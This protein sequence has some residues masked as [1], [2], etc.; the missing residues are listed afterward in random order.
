MKQPS[1]GVI[2]KD[3]LKISSKFT[4]EHPCQS[5]IS[6]KLHCNFI[7][8]TLR[9][10]CSPA[11]FLRIFKTPF[12]KKNS[13]GLLLKKNFRRCDSHGL[14]Q[15]IF[16][17]LDF[18][19]IFLRK[20]YQQGPNFKPSFQV[21]LKILFRESMGRMT[22]MH[23]YS[24]DDGTINTGHKISMVLDTRKSNFGSQYWLRFHIQFIV[25]LDYK[26]QQILLQN[27]TAILLQ[28]ATK[29][30]YKIRQI[31]YYKMPQLLQNATIQYAT[32]I[33]KCV[34]AR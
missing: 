19:K 34:G 24:K 3:V 28:N 18:I 4:G 7:E 27:A 20:S 10:G 25:T 17:T 11:N 23:Q 12:P 22:E 9:D 32:F 29:V 2:R 21:A 14:L 5:V 31:F 16:P 8:I 15:S 6:I 30:Y 33:T 1:R 13:C 26:M